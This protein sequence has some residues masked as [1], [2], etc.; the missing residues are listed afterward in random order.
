MTKDEYD[1]LLE[2]V[3]KVAKKLT[4]G[5]YTRTA[6]EQAIFSLEDMK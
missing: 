5:F 6:L 2:N 1:V 3:K 4:S